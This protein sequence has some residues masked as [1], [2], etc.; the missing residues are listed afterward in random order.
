MELTIEIN[1]EPQRVA[2]SLYVLKLSDD[3][4]RALENAMF[5]FRIT[6]GTEF[7]AKINNKGQFEIIS[8]LRESTLLTRR[9]YLTSQFTESEY[10]L[11]GDEIG[12]IGG[13]WQ[14]D[15]GNMAVVNLPK[16]NSIDIDEI[17]RIFNFNPT[18]I[19]D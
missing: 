19:T 4:F 5:D 10:R 7:Q 2:Y 8:I 17:F 18:E 15:F 13:F 14:V 11:L 9:F 6:F 12:R 3:T 16:D 1:N